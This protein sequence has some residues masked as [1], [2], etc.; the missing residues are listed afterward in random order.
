MKKS[1][2]FLALIMCLICSLPIFLTGCTIGGSG[3]GSGGGGVVGPGGGEDDDYVD[4]NENVPLIEEFADAVAGV[5]AGYI[6]DNATMQKEYETFEEH[7]QKSVE[8]LAK[9]ILYRLA[10]EYLAEIN[11]NNEGMTASNLGLLYSPKDNKYLKDYNTVFAPDFL[12]NKTSTQQ[13]GEEA[14]KL[15]NQEITFDVANYINTDT[16]WVK[17]ETVTIPATEET[18]QTTETRY[19]KQTGNLTIKRNQIV[20]FK[21]VKNDDGQ[22]ATIYYESASPTETQ[23]NATKLVEIEIIKSDVYDDDG[24]IENLQELSTIF[25]NTI[26]PE[27]FSKS[28]YSHKATYSSSRE[29]RSW[30][31][32]DGASFTTAQDYA[33]AYYKRLTIAI[34]LIFQGK[35]LTS[36]DC[37]S[38]VDKYGFM[39]QEGYSISGGD[40]S[41]NF[42][43]DSTVKELI[44]GIE[45]YGIRA[46]DINGNATQEL[47]NIASFIC[48][49]VIRKSIVD[50]DQSLFYSYNTD[51]NEYERTN[52]KVLD[53]KTSKRYNNADLN[54]L[55]NNQIA[56]SGSSYNIYSATS[57]QYLTFDKV[58]VDNYNN[59]NLDSTLLAQSSSGGYESTKQDLTMVA[60]FGFKNYMNTVDFVVSIACNACTVE[61]SNSNNSAVYSPV[62]NIYEYV[63][64]GLYTSLVNVETLKPEKMED[65]SDEDVSEDVEEDVEGGTEDQPEKISYANFSPQGEKNYQSLVIYPGSKEYDQI[66][67]GYIF[68]SFE[69]S[70]GCSFDL[71]F[72]YHKAG[73]GFS[74]FLTYK[75]VEGEQIPVY[76]TF[77]KL[78]EDN[79]AV[80]VPKGKADDLYANDQE[81][82]ELELDFEGALASRVYYNSANEKLE[83]TNSKVINATPNYN[84]LQWVNVDKPFGLNKYVANLVT[85]AHQTENNYKY[86]SNLF[87]FN[88]KEVAVMSYNCLEEEYIELLFVSDQTATFNYAFFLTEFMEVVNN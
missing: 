14:I 2:R 64:Q 88:D 86:V 43:Y 25:N 11:F 60:D 34:L 8:S 62:P 73:E 42:N 22:D 68:M 78:N 83:Q 85:E 5:R 69:S 52:F 47:K 20:N 81:V 67:V 45:H 71:Y 57:G 21:V 51:T 65:G 55:N 35:D 27:N 28:V 74:K 63:Q 33:N 56:L 76:S 10:G 72:R 1:K 15:K 84:N 70:T 31:W 9:D 37:F 18:Q 12:D 80:V 75:T 26:A 58:F 44:K 54:N 82:C 61:T 87:N 48:E 23:Q 17:A 29:H 4:P 46:K 3:S 41:F 50:I 66:L 19:I 49:Y 30:G 6:V 39:A 40:S 53:F 77:Y 79:E 7:A 38:D 16:V 24:Q 32:A 59:N 13:D 36:S